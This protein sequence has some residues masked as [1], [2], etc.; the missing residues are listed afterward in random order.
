VRTDNPKQGVGTDLPRGFGAVVKPNEREIKAVALLAAPDLSALPAEVNRK[1]NAATWP[2]PSLAGA[3]G[4]KVQLARDAGFSQ[5]IGEFKAASGSVDLA[6]APNG[7][8]HARVRGIDASGLEGFDAIKMVQIKD[9][10]VVVIAPPAPR[11]VWPSTLSVGASARALPNATLLI[12]NL[13]AIDTPV[14]LVAEIAV[15]AQFSQP[16]RAP[17]VN[18]QVT[19]PALNAGQAYFLRISTANAGNASVSYRLELPGNWASTVVE[20]QLALQLMPAR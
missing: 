10:P 4:Y 7:A 6:G 15:D 8:W 19:L 12:L 5:L 2:L 16:T 1:D 20:T 18:G 17:V 14:A 3:A 13:S 11:A 9:A